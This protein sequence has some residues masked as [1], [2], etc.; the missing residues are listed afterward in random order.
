VH[1]SG[2]GRRSSN[3]AG[4]GDSGGGYAEYLVGNDV[5]VGRRG[6]RLT[7]FIGNYLLVRCPC[8]KQSIKAIYIVS[9][10]A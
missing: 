7:Q 5:A 10:V 9:F 8:Y 3:P 6:S 4:I 1:A 2:P